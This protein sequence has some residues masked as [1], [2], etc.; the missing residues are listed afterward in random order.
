MARKA[1]TTNE[2]GFLGVDQYGHTYFLT[3]RTA[4]NTARQKLLS[5]LGAT[6]AIRMFVDG[7]DGETKHIGYIVGRLWITLYTVSEWKGK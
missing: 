6:K 4:G 1:I 2:L 3:A 7:A 5:M